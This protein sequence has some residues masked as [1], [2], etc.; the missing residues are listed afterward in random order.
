MQVRFLNLISICLI[1]LL[2]T[3]I[4]AQKKRSDS[5]KFCCINYNLPKNSI[6]LKV[7]L[8]T[9]IQ[10]SGKYARFAKKYLDLDIKAQTTSKKHQLISIDMNLNTHPDYYHNYKLEIPTE[11]KCVIGMTSDG[12]LESFNLKNSNKKNIDQNSTYI[13][14]K[15]K[16]ADNKYGEFTIS[17]V[18]KKQNDTIMKVVETDSSFHR[19]PVL[20]TNY[21]KKTEEEKAQEA[22]H[23]IFKLRKRRFKIL[24][25]N[26]D[27][28]P[29]DGKSYEIIVKELAEL[30]KK[31]LSLFIG[32]SYSITKEH[33]FIYK[34]KKGEKS[35]VLFYFSE[36]NGI[37]KTGVSGSTAIKLDITPIALSNLESETHPE[38]TESQQLYYKIP[39]TA[40]C[41]LYFGTDNIISKHYIISQ[42]GKL[43]SYSL[44]GLLK[45]KVQIKLSP[46]TGGIVY[47]SKEEQD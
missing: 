34:P 17:N 24:T 10:K 26:Y 13:F 47:L 5:D 18:L 36:N 14:S 16:F 9:K 37:T 33:T 40:E 31:Y 46:K 39:E 7:K 23:Q 22:A 11:H 32:E 44:E 27:K 8:K 12:I 29:P 6:E 35:K 4:N 21:L 45:N 15:S 42:L 2:S 41:N 3:N 38:L 20:K 28:L 30:E 19:V 25:A 43:A 1:L